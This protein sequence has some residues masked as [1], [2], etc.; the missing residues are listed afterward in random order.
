MVIAAVAPSS[1]P[2]VAHRVL[3]LLKLLPL[4][5]RQ[6]LSQSFIGLPAY[7]GDARLRLFSHCAQLPTRIGKNLFHLRFLL[8]GEL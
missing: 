3:Y 4:L 6:R 8:G 2:S 5:R 1:A 7:I